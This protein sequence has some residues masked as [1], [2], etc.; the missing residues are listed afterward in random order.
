MTERYHNSLLRQ[1]IKVLRN[2]Y[3]HTKIISAEYYRPVIAFLHKPGH[4]GFNSSTTL[5]TCCGAGGPPYNF[6]FSTGCGQPGIMACAHPSE[7]LQWDGYHLT[8]AAYRLIA[9]GWL[10]GPYADPPILHVAR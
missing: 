1:R 3:P 2:K 4:F 6:D 10:H 9:D 8:E 5:L 7:A